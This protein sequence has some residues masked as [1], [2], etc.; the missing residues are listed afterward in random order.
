MLEQS[1]GIVGVTKATLGSE[2]QNPGRAN[3]VLSY[4][5]LRDEGVAARSLK[6]Q[7]KKYNTTRTIIIVV[8]VIVTLGA[9]T[10]IFL[11]SRKKK[12]NQQILPPLDHTENKE[13]SIDDIV[14][15]LIGLD[16]DSKTTFLALSW[17]IGEMKV[18]VV[19]ILD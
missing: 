16:D 11:I 10:C 17:L 15:G 1:T 7:G 6:D 18:I 13:A 8:M 5:S 14:R 3:G 4:F 2:I 19:M 9:S 12:M